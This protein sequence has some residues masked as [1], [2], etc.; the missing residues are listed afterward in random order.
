M[1]FNVKELLILIW[2]IAYLNYI[3]LTVQMIIYSFATVLDHG[4]A[5]L[6]PVFALGIKF[7]V[8]DLRK[9]CSGHYG[10][11]S[12]GNLSIFHPRYHHIVPVI[13]DP[14]EYIKDVYLDL[15][16]PIISGLFLIIMLIASVFPFL[17]TVTNL[18]LK[19]SFTMKFTFISFLPTI[20][21]KVNKTNF[22]PYEVA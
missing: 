4:K 16:C 20:G 19:Y 15:F 13:F 22:K 18:L 17:D 14:V 21:K 7:H 11:L 10:H 8:L 9:N 12:E 2:S 6:G 3:S 1:F 5:P